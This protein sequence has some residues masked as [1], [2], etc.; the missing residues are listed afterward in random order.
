MLPRAAYLERAVD[1]GQ[2]RRAGH[3][4]SQLLARPRQVVEDPVHEGPRR[5]GVRILHQ[6]QG[7]GGGRHAIPPDRV[8]DAVQVV[9]DE[10]RTGRSPHVR[11][12]VRQAVAMAWPMPLLDPVTMAS[13]S[14]SWRSMVTPLSA[15][16]G[17]ASP[18]GALP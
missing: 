4:R 11:A 13:L 2:L 15:T 10:P 16:Q 14:R 17:I 3:R 9:G 1:I 5:F 18:T 12:L 8:D 7:F 6:H